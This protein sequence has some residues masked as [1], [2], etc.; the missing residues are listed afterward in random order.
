VNRSRFLPRENEGGVLES[1]E[2][3]RRLPEFSGEK[4]SFSKR[5]YL[6]LA[7]EKGDDFR[8]LKK[9]IF[10]KDD[11]EDNAILNELVIPKLGAA[12]RNHY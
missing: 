12:G 10:M 1:R 6:T 3:S 11:P 4:S 9:T 7:V 8:T 5:E 2:L